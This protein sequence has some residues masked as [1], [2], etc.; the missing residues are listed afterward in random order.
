[1]NSAPQTPSW[2]A[3]VPTLGA[4]TLGA[5]LRAIRQQ[6]PRPLLVVVAQGAISSAD[7]ALADRVVD[8]ASPR[9]FAVA[10]NAGLVEALGSGAPV[11]GLVNDD[12]R[13]EPAWA[14]QLLDELA[15]NPKLAAAQGTN[16]QTTA[17]LGDL[18]IGAS[19]LD[20]C[21]IAWNEHWQA[22]QRQHGESAPGTLAFTSEPIFGASATAALFRSEALRAV[23]GAGNQV[24]DPRLE[25]FYEDVELAV[26]LRA[27]GFEAAR[28]PSATALHVG[29]LT[30][31]R[32]PV[33]RWA[34]LTRN[35]RWVVA[36][37]LGRDFAAV[38]PT[39]ERRDRRDRWRAFLRGDLN[40]ARGI[41]RGCAAA[42]TRLSE[43][44][45]DGPPRVD[46][47]MLARFGA[48]A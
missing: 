38:V 9:G 39:I 16:W 11:V 45:H 35:R 10:A 34:L 48:P 13:I 42:E 36:S 7:L 27:L 19:T 3:V 15:A 6:E 18:E 4:P 22:V 30:T 43:F 5:A 47:R 24:L 32:R 37:L 29:S 2:A 20:G 1:M 23:A 14:S 44:A 17:D 46:R 21:G 8:L 28:V 12:A 40:R 25:T 33:E 31:S 26:R 41:A